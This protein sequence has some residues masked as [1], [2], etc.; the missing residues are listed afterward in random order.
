[1][2]KVTLL[3]APEVKFIMEKLGFSFQSWEIGCL[4]FFPQ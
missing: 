3:E 2:E 1:M 4:I